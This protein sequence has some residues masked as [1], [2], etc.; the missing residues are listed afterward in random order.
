MLVVLELAIRA[1]ARLF[2]PAPLPA[3]ARAMTDS[4][5]AGVLTGGPRAPGSLLRTHLGLDFARSWA[6]SYLSAAHPACHIRYRA[7]LLGAD[8]T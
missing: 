6:L 7:V 2:L 5:L 3:N 1:L 4:I 8:G